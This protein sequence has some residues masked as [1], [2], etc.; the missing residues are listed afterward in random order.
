[1]SCCKKTKPVESGVHLTERTCSPYN[2]IIKQLVDDCLGLPI[3]LITSIDAV[4]DEDGKTLRDLLEELQNLAGDNNPEIQKIWVKINEILEDMDNLDYL[5]ENSEVIINLRQ[6]LETLQQL[7][8][9]IARMGDESDQNYYSNGIPYI[10][11][12][13]ND[14]RDAIGNNDDPNSLA[15][16][17]NSLLI[18]VRAIAEYDTEYEYDQTGSNPMLPII[19]EIEA[20]KTQLE[21]WEIPEDL[22]E[23][24]SAIEA[25]IANLSETLGKKANL[26]DELLEQGVNKLEADEYPVT[27]MKFLNSDDIPNNP[28]FYYF[29]E[30]Y[31]VHLSKRDRCDIYPIR[32]LDGSHDEL[33][34]LSDENG[35]G[36]GVNGQ[37]LY[38]GN[39]T[40]DLQD[41]TICRNAI[42]GDIFVFGFELKQL[43]IHDGSA[44]LDTNDDSD[45]PNAGDLNAIIDAYLGSD[46]NSQQISIFGRSHALQVT[47]SG[48]WIWHPLIDGKVYVDTTTNSPYRFF[49]HRNNPRM[50][51]LID[52]DMV[53]DGDGVTL[54]KSIVENG[55]NVH[56]Q[57]QLS[58]E[59]QQVDNIELEAG[60]NITINTTTT[61]GSNKT[62]Y[63]ISANVPEIA[64]LKAGTNIHI[65]TQEETNELEISSNDTIT[66]ISGDIVNVV[67]E[68]SEENS[69]NKNYKIKGIDTRCQVVDSLDSLPNDGP[70]YYIAP[71]KY[72]VYNIVRNAGDDENGPNFTPVSGD[73]PIIEYKVSD[74]TNAIDFLL[75]NSGNIT[76]QQQQKQLFRRRQIALVEYW[77]T[78][79]QSLYLT[80]DAKTNRTAEEQRQ[81]EI[82]VAIK[83]HLEQYIVEDLSTNY[84][85]VRVRPYEDFMSA[86][87]MDMPEERH[88]GYEVF[89]P[90][91]TETLLTFS[92]NNF[93]I[94]V[95]THENLDGVQ[96]FELKYPSTPSTHN[97]YKYTPADAGVRESVQND[98]IQQT[99]RGEA[100]AV[101]V[102]LVTDIIDSLLSGSGIPSSQIRVDYQLVKREGTDIIPVTNTQESNSLYGV[103]FVNTEATNKQEK[104]WTYTG[105]QMERILPYYLL[106]SDNNEITLYEDNECNSIVSVNNEN[107][108]NVSFIASQQEVQAVCTDHAVVLIYNNNIVDNPY[109]ITNVADGTTLEFTAYPVVNQ[110][111]D[112]IAKVATYTYT[113][114][115]NQETE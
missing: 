107:V 94:Y 74:V 103:I 47:A 3:Y 6:G 70:Q 101:R 88:V 22:E 24:L 67:I 31:E 75:G 78:D 95:R 98:I 46:E 33:W 106:G 58:F 93:Y 115:S 77:F 84:S 114:T 14:L 54:T 105:F 5:T 25:D 56:K 62:K 59:T 18:L 89:N 16:K 35:N 113:K 85:Q 37:S 52:V 111:E 11:K 4:I 28:G 81:Y 10:V 43:R 7:V 49:N 92:P 68:E 61:P 44:L 100:D 39:G 29:P 97:V 12:V 30:A 32:P 21:N 48:K 73:Y 112:A 17:L 76:D 40:I 15:G 71:A 91:T 1:M 110:G 86:S 13:I 82:L 99:L 57:Y 64:T 72:E 26:D 2:P 41:I 104:F 63:T 55:D 83:N 23:R 34:V 60:D 66:S 9:H 50:V 8:Q 51:P 20:L 53:V 102:K 109:D 19:K 87:Q 90:K 42:L 69:T 65:E 80:L 36:V 79:L 108:L 38:A 45:Y 27:S 96:G